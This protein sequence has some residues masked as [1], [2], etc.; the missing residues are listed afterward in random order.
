MDKQFF[1]KLD[2]L[3]CV[4]SLVVVCVF[5]GC[6]SPSVSSHPHITEG[7]G[8]AE[9]GSDDDSDELGAKIETITDEST[10]IVVTRLDGNKTPNPDGVLLPWV[11]FNLSHADGFNVITP[12]V[13]GLKDWIFIESIDLTIDGEHFPGLKGEADREVGGGRSKRV[14][15]YLFIPIDASLARK[16]SAASTIKVR[17]VGREGSI[18]RELSAANVTNIRTFFAK[19]G[20]QAQSA[21]PASDPNE[22]L[23]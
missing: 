10:G 7:A 22:T 1:K 18:S 9:V 20:V 2:G 4:V 19:V 23:E 17:V 16:L 14:N 12:A 21:A 8:V 5:G 15:E 6:A 3:L 13:F 11:I